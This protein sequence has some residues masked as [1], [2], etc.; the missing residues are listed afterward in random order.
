MREQIAMMLLSF[1]GGMH[2]G[3]PEPA[4]QPGLGLSGPAFLMAQPAGA[5]ESVYV[6]P[7]VGDMQG[8][9]ND[10]AL[11]IDITA[12]YMTDYIYRGLEVVE[13][14]TPEDA[15]NFQL[16][17]ELRLDLGRLPDPFFRV[18]TNTAE[19]DDISNFQI[20]RPAVGLEWETEA[21]DIALGTQSYTYPDRTDLDTAEAFVDLRFNDGVLYSEEGPILGPFIVAVWDFDQYEGLYVEGGLRRTFDVADTNVRITVEGVVAY[22]HNYGLYSASA[23]NDGTGFSHYQVGVTG[24][25]RLNTLL[26]ISRRYGQWSLAGYLNY[27]DGIDNEL[28]ATTQVWGGG[29]I[30]FRY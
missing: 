29:G 17:A 24:E 6:P 12:R 25:Y 16:G 1:L 3:A 27:T 19:G 2:G 5:Q 7:G 4:A 22:V 20:I 30:V 14:P 8:G 10:G 11:S 13:P 23:D 26:N 15:I 9:Y 18:L 21:F 28:A